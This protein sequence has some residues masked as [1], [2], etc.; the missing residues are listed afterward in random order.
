MGALQ[1]AR[2]MTSPGLTLAG[3]PI[4]SQR[5]HSAP[6]WPSKVRSAGA[7][8]SQCRAQTQTEKKT[9]AITA[10]FKLS[11]LAHTTCQTHGTERFA[12]EGTPIPHRFVHHPAH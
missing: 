10:G 9:A 2:C 5:R 12:R 1:R 8:S 6:A 4:A 11:E 7:G 3:A